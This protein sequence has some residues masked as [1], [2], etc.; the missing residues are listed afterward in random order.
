MSV[1]Q[2]LKWL[3]GKLGRHW[4]VSAPEWLDDGRGPISALLVAQG[5]N[6]IETTVIIDRGTANVMVRI[7]GAD[8][9]PFE[10]LAV[11]KDVLD[12]DTLL[13]RVRNENP[14]GEME[15]PII[16][17]DKA[18]EYV[19]EWGPQLA[20]NLRDPKFVQRLRSI[21]DKVAE[22]TGFFN[23]PPA[24]PPPEDTASPGMGF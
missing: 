14:Q 11:A 2:A 15:G 4:T 23:E 10:D 8:P 21:E 22:A 3:R 24:P 13:T 16:G 6:K 12:L 18:L 5:P 7:A 1:E 20:R 19:S 9:V 17:V